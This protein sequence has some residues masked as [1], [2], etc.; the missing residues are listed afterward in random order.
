MA[1]LLTFATLARI[2]HL[3]LKSAI[4]L[5]HIQLNAHMLLS[6]PKLA[7]V[8]AVGFA[9]PVG[10][11]AARAGLGVI[12]DQRSPHSNFLYLPDDDVHQLNMRRPLRQHLT[13]APIPE[14]GRGVRI[15]K[16]LIPAP[17][18]PFGEANLGVKKAHAVLSVHTEIEKTG[19]V[20]MTIN[21]ET[22]AKEA[23]DQDSIF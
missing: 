22:L 7:A 11:L 3:W 14:A 21:S 10:L 23:T 19:L 5:G 9:E 1:V 4:G 8:C 6:L 16:G 17:L 15:T 2:C 12:D 13:A 20:T 18:P